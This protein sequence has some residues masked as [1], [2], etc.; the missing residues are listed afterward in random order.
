MAALT[1]RQIEVVRAIMVT[2][3]IAGAADLLNVSAPGISRLMKYTESALGM[4]LFRR[5]RGRYIPTPEATD[6][7]D[8]INDVYRTVDQLQYT[9]SRIEQ[10]D[11]HRVNLAAV[12]SIGRYLAPRAIASLRRKYDKLEISYDILKIEE[13]IEAI[14]LKRVDLVAISYRFDHPGIVFSPLVAGRLVC[15]APSDHPMA[16]KRSVSLSE[17]AGATLIGVE[18]SDPYGNLMAEAFR[19]HGLDYRLS[20]RVRFGQSAC[21]LVAN[22]LG[23][24]VV[25]EFTVAGESIADLRVLPIREK[26]DFQTYAASKADAPLSVYAEDFVRFLR[27]EMRAAT[28]TKSR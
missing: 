9:I 20:I 21:A 13:A 7:F 18:A 25:D 15:I 16:R 23:L 10:G 11:S 14:T 12:P 3:T 19:K 8:R 2:G 5:H 22:G 24:A 17:L 6:I 1:L 4:R 26:T 28:N 27:Q